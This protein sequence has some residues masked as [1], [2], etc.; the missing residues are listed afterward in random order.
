MTEVAAIIL[1]A[2]AS[3]RLGR[4]KQLEEIN[5]ETLLARSIRTAQEAGC[6]PVIVVLGAAAEQIL[7]TV[8][9]AH[10][11]VAV[12]MRW[13]E[14][15]GGSLAVGVHT[16]QGLPELIQG[17]VLLT[18]DMPFITAS[19][20]RA[21]AATGMLTGSQYGN[22]IGVPAYIPSRFLAQLA[23]AGGDSG[24]RSL[25]QQAQAVPLPCGDLDIDTEQDLQRARAYLQSADSSG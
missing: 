4:P 23:S 25:L 14:G 2:G 21:L 17:A 15:M 20:L 19:H 11:T 12:N 7:R 10:C 13:P 22:A 6:S 18:C 16:L 24:A 9:L 5:S 1:A 3:R 8:D